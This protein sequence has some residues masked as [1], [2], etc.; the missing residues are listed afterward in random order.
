M[1]KRSMIEEALALST[2]D[3]MIL[4]EEIWDSIADHPDAVELT[5][6]QRQLLDNRLEAYQRDPQAGSTWK[7]LKARVKPTV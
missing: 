4:L 5:D 2:E 7:E 6:V 1:I 3:R